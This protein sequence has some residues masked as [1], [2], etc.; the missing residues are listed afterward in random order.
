MFKSLKTKLLVY[1]FIANV[2]ILVGFSFFI[3]STAKS[4]VEKNLD[5]KLKILSQ[6]AIVDLIDKNK[7]EAGD[8]SK[9]LSEEFQIKPLHV[10]IVYYDSLKNKIIFEHISSN[11]FK[12]LFDIPLHENSELDDIYYY[13]KD[14]F[15]ISSMFLDQKEDIKIFFQLATTKLISTPYLQDLKFSLFIAVPFILILFMIIVN[16]LISKT[17]KP[18][19]EVVKSAKEISTIDLSSRISTQNIPSEIKELVDTFNDLLSNIEEAFSRVSTFSSDASHELKTP[20]TV[21]RGEIEVLLKKNRDTQEYKDTLELVLFEAISIEETI[22]QLFLLSKKDTTEFSEN[23]EEVY[24]D[25]LIGDIVKTKTKFADK[26]NIQI[27]VDELTPYSLQV[28]EALVKIAINNIV[29]N[30][31]LYSDEDKEIHI[32]FS[33]ENNVYLL[34]IMDN[35]Y[36][37]SK[38]NLPY[39]FDRFYRVDKVRNRQ[40]SG[41]GLGLAIVKMILD[42]YNFDIEVSSELGIGTTTVIKLNMNKS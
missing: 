19:K 23:V 39:I 33:K 6:D 38:E 13:D 34:K 16:L 20:L 41:T 2:I 3:Y 22:S 42:I 29:T 36:G 8:I 40:K 10:K 30:S 24:I 12:N 26:K 15:R 7:S 14:E 28:N 17:L 11:N 5:S 37:M 25:E 21:I 9:D 35:G 32:S 1:F 31:I 27:I 18:M 4:G